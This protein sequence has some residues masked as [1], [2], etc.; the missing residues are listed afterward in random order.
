MNFEF[1]NY[2]KKVKVLKEKY[3]HRFSEIDAQFQMDL[4]LL[5]QS[6]ENRFPD[7]KTKKVFIINYLKSKEEEKLGKIS[8]KEKEKSTKANVAEIKKIERVLIEERQEL[9][10][11]INTRKLLEMKDDN[12][13]NEKDRPMHSGANSMKNN[14]GNPP[15][16]K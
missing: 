12:S 1:L 16:N 11:I 8:E 3:D 7:W 2:I 4:F 13:G 9:V 5:E 10:T 6:Y 15:D 14:G